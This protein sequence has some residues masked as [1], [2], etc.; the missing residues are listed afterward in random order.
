MGIS[1]NYVSLRQFDTLPETSHP[2]RFVKM[3]I[4]IYVKF[5]KL[6]G[7]RALRVFAPLRFT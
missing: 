4:L 6:R 7:L 5:A 3:V 2:S 1:K